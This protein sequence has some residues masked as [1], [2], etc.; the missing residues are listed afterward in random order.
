MQEN[1]KTGGGISQTGIEPEICVV[2]LGKKNPPLFKNICKKALG[3]KG[4]TGNDCLSKGH[5]EGTVII[6]N[7]K[8]SKICVKEDGIIKYIDFDPSIH[9]VPSEGGGGLDTS[10]KPVYTVSCPDGYL[11]PKFLKICGKALNGGCNTKIACTCSGHLKGTIIYKNGQP[12]KICVIEGD[13]I[14]YIPFD[15]VVSSKEEDTAKAAEAKTDPEIDAIILRAS[16]VIGSSIGGISSTEKPFTFFNVLLYG[17][18]NEPEKKSDVKK[19]A[20]INSMLTYI[21]GELKSIEGLFQA[22]GIEVGPITEMLSASCVYM[23]GFTLKD[24]T[25]NTWLK[26]NFEQMLNC[27]NKSV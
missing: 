5:D 14:K 23:E 1:F 17:L 20:S 8:P 25:E 10:P 9:S 6:E 7:G 15:A 18:I 13:I 19:K 11:P 26:Y 12:D 22:K 27:F 4:C 24:S 3:G 21:E 2:C 16:V